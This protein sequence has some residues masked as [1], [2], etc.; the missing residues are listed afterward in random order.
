LTFVLELETRVVLGI[1]GRK[2]DSARAGSQF[3]VAEVVKKR[4][5]LGLFYYFYALF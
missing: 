2:R 4:L 1:K 3:D 5:G